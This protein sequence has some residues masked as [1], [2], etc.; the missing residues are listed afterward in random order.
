MYIPYNILYGIKYIITYQ[1]FVWRSWCVFVLHNLQNPNSFLQVLATLQNLFWYLL[2]VNLCH[3]QFCKVTM[4]IYEF[5]SI[6]NFGKT[7]KIMFYITFQKKCSF[8]FIKWKI[9]LLSWNHLKLGPKH[10]MTYNSL[11]TIPNPLKF[12]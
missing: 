3:Q 1:F 7:W 4:L 2:G 10:K 11:S 8:D 6:W 9:L 5:E 12:W